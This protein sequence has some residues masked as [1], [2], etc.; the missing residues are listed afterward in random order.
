M[1]RY[2][3]SD[4][5]LQK[6]DA[7]LLEKKPELAQECTREE[8]LRFIRGLGIDNL[9]RVEKDLYKYVNFR[10]NELKMH[11]EHLASLHP[12]GSFFDEAFYRGVTVTEERAL[13]STR[14]AY[15][16]PATFKV[17]EDDVQL[18]QEGLTVGKY[19][20]LTMACYLDS[21]LARDSFDRL[22]VIFDARY[23]EG[24]N[25]GNPSAFSLIPLFRE[26]V[27][28]LQAIFQERLRQIVMFPLPPAAMYVWGVIK[29][30]ID[31]ESYSRYVLIG[32]NKENSGVH[33][34][35]P[36]QLK[37]IIHPETVYKLEK[38]RRDMFLRKEKDDLS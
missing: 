23:G 16:L 25:F 35:P 22:T 18:Y 11:Q 6:A 13:D 28:I 32:A 31:K 7:K 10:Q 2:D 9:E 30:F 36:V 21:M 27:S 12:D 1:S 17:D 5:Q 33:S 8:R 15:I 38:R 14:I 4:E 26:T 3:V 29:L 37:E 24:E 34:D 20:A 19:H